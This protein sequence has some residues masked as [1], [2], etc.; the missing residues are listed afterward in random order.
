MTNYKSLRRKVASTHGLVVGIVL[1]VMALLVWV[2]DMQQAFWMKYLNWAVVIGSV[3]YSMKTWRDQH[4]GGS[5]SYSQ[6]LG[7]GVLVMFFAS[8]LFGFYNIIYINYLDP[9]SIQRSMDF[10]EETYYA[11][12]RSEEQIEMLLE[13]ASGMQTPF[14]Q[15]ISTIFG[16]TF[17]GLLISLIVALFIRKDGDPF[18]EAMKGVSEQNQ[19]EQ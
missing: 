2:A 17:L 19:E 6:A 14:I 18:Q 13:V 1:I 10:L 5:I 9:E 4:L 12:G 7:Y 3:Y 11:Q 15:A 16:T 8:I